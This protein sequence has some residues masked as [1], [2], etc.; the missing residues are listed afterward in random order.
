VTRTTHV[1]TPAEAFGYE[2]GAI[3]AA[4]RRRDQAA[5]AVPQSWRADANDLL[6]ARLCHPL[7]LLAM[8][9]RQ[10]DATACTC[11]CRGRYHGALTF[12][13]VLPQP[14]TCPACGAIA[15][16]CARETMAGPFCC[17]TCGHTDAV[18]DTARHVLRELAATE[19]AGT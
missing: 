1:P 11:T 9:S 15:E 10:G 8:E 3:G 4:Q 16:D 13:E 6:E 5:A 17:E 2:P 18:L 7:C 12:A 19:A 14:W